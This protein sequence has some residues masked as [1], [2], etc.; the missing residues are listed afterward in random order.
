V[1]AKGWRWKSG[2]FVRSKGAERAL[3]AAGAM[4][5]AT[6]DRI[7][8]GI[9]DSDLRYMRDRDSLRDGSF[10]VVEAVYAKELAAGRSATEIA[11]RVLS[12]IQIAMYSDGTMALTDG[13]H[14]MITAR[15]KGATAIRALVVQ[16]GPRGGIRDQRELVVPL[17]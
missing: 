9:D 13:R 1:A 11:T 17:K 16:Y 7:A 2:S 8:R 12:P 6:Y 10:A 4:Q 3:K 15:R 14:R 5:E